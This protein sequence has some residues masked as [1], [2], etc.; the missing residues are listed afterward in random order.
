MG[1]LTKFKQFRY[2]E[3][4]DFDNDV[5]IMLPEIRLSIYSLIFGLLWILL[6]DNIVFALL[7]PRPDLLAAVQTYN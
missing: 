3:V 5:T 6:S 4:R 1:L 2:D 7:G